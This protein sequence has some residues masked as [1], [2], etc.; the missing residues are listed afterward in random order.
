M[1]DYTVV[2]W[3]DIAN[4]GADW[5]IPEEKFEM[6]IGRGP[7]GCKEHGVTFARFGKGFK[8]TFGHTHKHQEEVYVI[9]SGTAEMNIDGKISEVS[10][11]S[12]VRVAP[13]VWRALRAKGDEDMTMIVT[14]APV[15]GEDDGEINLEWWPA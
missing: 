14:G 12:A 3:A 4:A 13:G 6:R 2:K 8:P 15:V 11:G 7:L 9:L 10:A 5:G 1:S